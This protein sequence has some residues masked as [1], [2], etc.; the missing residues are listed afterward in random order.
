MASIVACGCETIETCEPATS[1]IVAPAR[2]A[3]W[4]WVSGGIA[5]SSV[6]T[7]VQLGSIWLS[8]SPFEGLIQNIT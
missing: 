1:V 6:P 4:R 3:M 2:S 5:R 7:T 8:G